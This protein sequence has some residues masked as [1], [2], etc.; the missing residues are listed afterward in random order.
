MAGD[1]SS[2]LRNKLVDHSLGTTAYAKPAAV[3]LAA[4]VGDPG[5]TGVE[6]AGNGYARQAVTFNASSGSGE[7]PCAAASNADATFPVATGSWGTVD[8]LALYDAATGG[9]L[10]WYGPMTVS[11]SI[12]L[13]DQL[14]VASGNFTV[15][16][17]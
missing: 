2:Y 8:N 14:K 6:V 13:G 3:Y 10:L 1:A 12:G 17:S 7:N 15:S 9:D 16:L 4:F 5:S 11:K